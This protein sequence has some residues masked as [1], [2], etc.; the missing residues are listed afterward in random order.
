MHTHT[1]TYVILNLS[2]AAFDE[3][4]AKLADAGYDHAFHRDNERGWV[5]DMNGLAVAVDKEP[6][7]GSVTAQSSDAR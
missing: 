3:I 1:R 6:A 5:I 7:E 4:K 2:R